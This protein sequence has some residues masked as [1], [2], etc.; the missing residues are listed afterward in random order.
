V[1]AAGIEPASESLPSFDNYVRSPRFEFGATTPTDGMCCTESE[2]IS[3]FE[4]Q[5]PRTA[6]SHY[7]DPAPA[8][9]P[10]PGGSLAY[11][12]LSCSK[13]VR[14]LAVFPVRICVFASGFTRHQ[15]LGT[16]LRLLYPRRNQIR[17][18]NQPSFEGMWLSLQDSFCRFQTALW[19]APVATC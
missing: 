3:P 13:C 16:R 8:H 5:T 6:S 14:N 10:R 11:R 9:E 4:S 1:E 7:D 12:L 2:I 17:M 19:F 18:M 15:Q